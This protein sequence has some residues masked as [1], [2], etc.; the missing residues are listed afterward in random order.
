MGI[1]LWNIGD[2]HRK[3]HIKFYVVMLMQFCGRENI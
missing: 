1:D 2:P 3:L